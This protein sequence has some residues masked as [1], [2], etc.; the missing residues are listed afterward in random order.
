MNP[1]GKL[2]IIEMVIP[3]D[4]DPHP[5][6]MLDIMMLVGPGGQERTVPEYHTLLGKAKLRVSRVVPTRSAVTIIESVRS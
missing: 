2:L 5:G 1:D 3:E 6:K 4:N